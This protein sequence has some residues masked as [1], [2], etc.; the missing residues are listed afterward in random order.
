[1]EI[2]CNTC[3]EELG[4]TGTCE[5]CQRFLLDDSAR[6][7]SEEDA[8]ETVEQL[9]EFLADPPWYARFAPRV[10]WARAG[11][12]GSVVKDYFEGD[13][14]ELPWRSIAAIAATIVYVV[15]PV[16][17]IPDVLIPIGWT[18]DMVVVALLF[19]ALGFDLT[20][21]ATAKGLA[22]EKYGL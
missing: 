10:L 11:L 1:M 5:D 4:T 16:D 6:N 13:Y 22:P 12:M 3:D 15:S 21:Y 19:E 14:K 18:D 17:L 2:I 8:A 20:V 7:M 9:E